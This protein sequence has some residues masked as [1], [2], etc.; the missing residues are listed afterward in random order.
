MGKPLAGRVCRLVIDWRTRTMMTKCAYTQ[1]FAAPWPWRHISGFT[2]SPCLAFRQNRLS[3]NVLKRGIFGAIH[4]T[5]AKGGNCKSFKTA[6]TYTN[7]CLE[8]QLYKSVV[9]NDF[10]DPILTYF[11]VNF[12]AFF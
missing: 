7:P 2:A 3:P 6:P 12:D 10:S 11:D 9:L 5:L 8:C 4:K 1:L